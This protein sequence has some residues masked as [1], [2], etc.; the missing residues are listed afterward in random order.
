M[1]ELTGYTKKHSRNLENILRRSLKA[2]I[3]KSLGVRNEFLSEFKPR[4]I[5]NPKNGDESEEWD[6]V[7]LVTYDEESNAELS[8]IVENNTLFLLEVKS[9]ILNTTE[10]FEKIDMKLKNTLSSLKPEGVVSSK[11]TVQNKL[12]KQQSFFLDDSH[13]IVA[14]GSRS[15]DDADVNTIIKAGYLAVSPKRNWHEVC[16][17]KVEQ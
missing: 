15:L 2:Y 13:I 5:V 3:M 10:I 8:S 16:K 7:Y 14:I 12:K 9:N 1:H 6:A 11:K 4:K 17:I